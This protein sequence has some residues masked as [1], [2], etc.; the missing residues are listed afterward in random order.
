MRGRERGR[1]EGGREGGRGGGE[2]N[3]EATTTTT[4][5]TRERERWKGGLRD[6][7]VAVE[8]S[9]KTDSFSTSFEKSVLFGVEADAE[10]H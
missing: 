5:G 1:R 2:V 10:V 3:F 4:N 6:G 8:R 9:C 7:R